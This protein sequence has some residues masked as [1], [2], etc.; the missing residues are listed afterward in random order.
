MIHPTQHQRGQGTAL[1]VA[2]AHA[3]SGFFIALFRDD[4]EIQL[5]DRH[6]IKG[7]SMETP[8][9]P[10]RP[11][12]LDAAMTD[13]QRAA[14]YRVRRYEAASM[15]HENLDNA[16]TAVLLAG[17]ARQIKAIDDPGHADVARG[18]A[19]Q[20]IKQLCDRH[21]IKFV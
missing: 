14:A 3:A 13:K 5:C 10:G 8:K 11:T 6:I 15:A 17:L 9:K 19:G 20:I 2:G 12:K 1:R 18:I 16:T 4:H 21:E 7:N